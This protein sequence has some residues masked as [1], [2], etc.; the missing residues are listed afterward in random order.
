VALSTADI[1]RIKAEL[2]WNVLTVGAEPFIGVAAIFSQVIQPYMTA[3]AS[4]TTSST[5]TAA[6]TP[7]PATLVL[8]DP[9]GFSAGDRVF[10]DVDDLQESGTIRSLSGSNLGVLLRLAH[11]GTYPVTVDGGEGIV[12]EILKNIRD[13][14]RELAQT[15]GEGAI[16]QVDEVSFYSTRDR[17]MFGNL[18]DQLKYWRRELSQILTNGQGINMWERAL[19]SAQ[20]LSVY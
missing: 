10:V 18:G 2:G 11:T 14:K 3:G 7:T 15:F 4:T 16:K 13:V 17:T 19:A 12:R 5:V 9:T 1:T 20:R 6:T 8:T